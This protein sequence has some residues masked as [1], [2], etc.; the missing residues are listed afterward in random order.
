MNLQNRFTLSFAQFVKVV[1]L[2]KISIVVQPQLSKL[3]RLI[4]LCGSIFKLNND[5]YMIQGFI[6]LSLSNTEIQ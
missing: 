3:Y 6:S 2:S 1:E 4:W 5:G